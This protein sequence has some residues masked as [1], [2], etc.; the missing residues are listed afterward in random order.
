M[1]TILQLLAQAAP[2][3]SATS[4]SEIPTTGYPI[5]D[6]ILGALVAITTALTFATPIVLR[7]VRQV[8]T[9]GD[10][11]EDLGP[12]AKAKAEEKAKGQGV[13]LKAVAEG[14]KARRTLRIK[15]GGMS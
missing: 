13:D 10:V 9:L 1:P 6:G 2:V 11:I 12:D 8:Q 4:A 3:T 5:L 7:L 15:K 14:A